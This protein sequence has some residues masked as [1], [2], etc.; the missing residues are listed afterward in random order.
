MPHAKRQARHR[1]D[2]VPREVPP[3]RVAEARGVEHLL[4]DAE[5]QRERAAEDQRVPS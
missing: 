2:D 4:R 5:T 1:A 3:R